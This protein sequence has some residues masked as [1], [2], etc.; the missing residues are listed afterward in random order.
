MIP[1]DIPNFKLIEGQIKE[2]QGVVPKT[3]RAENDHKS[4][5]RIG[6]S[7]HLLFDLTKVERIAYHSK[8]FC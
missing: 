2:Q 3:L 1:I 7:M 6:L 4:P 8:H 5:S